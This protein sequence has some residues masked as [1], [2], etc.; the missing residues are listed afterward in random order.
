MEETQLEVQKVT[1]QH[2]KSQQ[3]VQALEDQLSTMKD[4]KRR[5]TGFDM[6]DYKAEISK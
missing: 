3:A 6:E 1:R 2:K 4:T 5:S